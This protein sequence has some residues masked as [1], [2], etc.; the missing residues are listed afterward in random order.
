MNA[1]PKEEREELIGAVSARDTIRTH[2]AKCHLS[3][4]HRDC[5]IMKLLRALDATEK[6]LEDL[7]EKSDKLCKQLHVVHHDERYA[8]VWVNAQMLCGRPYDGPC[9]T[10]E[11]DA[12]LEAIAAAKESP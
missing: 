10:D 2:H 4:N 1:F 9:Y 7:V 8:G 6:K 12:L 11:L 5:A 3:A